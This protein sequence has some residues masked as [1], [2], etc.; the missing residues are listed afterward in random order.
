MRHKAILSLLSLF[1]FASF[2]LSSAKDKNIRYITGYIQNVDNNL[3]ILS[4]NL[5]FR[6]D[7]HI[8]A[9]SMMPAV[10]ILEYNRPEGFVYI[11]DKKIDVTLMKKSGGKF[12]LPASKEDLD[13]YKEG[14]LDEIRGLSKNNLAVE[15]NDSGE[16]FL[17]D[18]SEADDLNNWQ[19]GDFVIIAEQKSSGSKRLINTRTSDKIKVSQTDEVPVIE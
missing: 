17:T 5:A 18:K 6:T 14:K 15:L 16:W 8:T 9:I 10:F 3:I 13:I 2:S 12:L 4:N 11:K 19:T 7:Q 1:M